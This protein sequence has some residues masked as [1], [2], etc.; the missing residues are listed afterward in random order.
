[1]SAKVM[2]SKIYNFSWRNL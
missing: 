1:L 2:N